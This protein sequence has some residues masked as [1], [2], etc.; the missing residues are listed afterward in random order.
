MR[1]NPFKELESLV[2]KKAREGAATHHCRDPVSI[3]MKCV[4]G[5]RRAA[6]FCNSLECGIRKCH[7]LHE[8]KQSTVSLE[9]CN[10]SVPYA[11]FVGFSGWW[12]SNN[13]Q[14]LSSVRV[15]LVFLDIILIRPRISPL[16]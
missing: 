1:R 12:T 10:Y 9:K 11:R 15:V 6:K 16:R 2:T 14:D 3:R 7:F 5:S 8:R 4:A 13:D